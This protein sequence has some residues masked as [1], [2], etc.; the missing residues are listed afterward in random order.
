[1]NEDS[2]ADYSPT[3]IPLEYQQVV[4]AETIKRAIG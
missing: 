1:M 3:P 4:Q 2:D